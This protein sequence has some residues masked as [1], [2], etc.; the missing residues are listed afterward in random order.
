M[1]CEICKCVAPSTPAA[2]RGPQRLRGPGACKAWPPPSPLP[3][4]QERVGSKI[5]AIQPGSGP[6]RATSVNMNA[7]LGMEGNGGHGHGHGAG[8]T[9]MHDELMRAMSQKSLQ[10]P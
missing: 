4:A 1:R 6:S 7:L 10:K 8:A 3:R 5:M 2:L 9:N